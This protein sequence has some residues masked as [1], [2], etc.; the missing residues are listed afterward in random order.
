MRLPA[1][2][3]AQA[4]AYFITVCTHHRELLL[5]DDGI[6]DVVLQ[7][8]LSLPARFPSVVLDEFVVMPNHVHG[9]MVLGGA[10]SGAPTQ[11]AISLATAVR[12]FKS[13]SAVAGNKLLN[14]PGRPF[15]QRTYYEHIVRNEADLNRIRQYIRDNPAN[16][17]SDPENPL[18]RAAAPG[19]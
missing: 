12:A 17:E 8:W 11:D 18:A 15:W 4:G 7:A 10:A 5:V 16:W 6:R 14:R 1:Y 9:V 19:P 2:D 13:L 3:Y